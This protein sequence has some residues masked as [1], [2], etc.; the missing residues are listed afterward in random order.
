MAMNISFDKRRLI[1]SLHRVDDE[2]RDKIIDSYIELKKRYIKS[3]FNDEH[4]SVGLTSGK[5][6]EII[7]RFLEK[8][9]L[10]KF[11][12]FDKHISNFPAELNKLSQ[13]KAT[14]GNESL[15]VIIPRALAFIYTL[16][17]KRGIGHSGGE[18]EAN[19]IDIGTIVKSA[20]WI[21]CEL[22]RLYHNL[23]LEEAQG[24]IDSLNIKAIPEIWNIDENR[25]VIKDGFS[26][27][28]KVLLLLYNETDNKSS[29]N[30]LYDWCEYSTL[31]NFK[32]RI[33]NPLHK[34][35]LIE[36]NPISKE[37]I[38]SPTGIAQAEMLL[39]NSTKDN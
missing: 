9:V 8:E 23:T 21:I 18:V 11:T 5:F 15:R 38:I 14:S 25:R 2:F 17:N 34:K 22:I 30:Q 39:L 19:S 6:C 28:Q 4:D 32:N 35:K 13:A 7:F 26:F 31:S 24:V 10:D 1:N 33:I 16:R 3:F 36:F 27:P 20:D 12:P 29:L 37:V